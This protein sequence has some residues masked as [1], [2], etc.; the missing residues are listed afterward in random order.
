MEKQIKLKTKDGHTIYGILNTSSKKSSI[1]AVFV[2]GLTGHPNEHTFH[3]A[4]QQFPKKGVDVFRF[5]LYTG[6]KGGRKLSECTLTTHTEDLNKVLNHFR[7]KYKTIA[8]VGHSLGSPT[9]LK[10]DTSKVDSIVLWDPS[11]LAEDSGDRPN[12]K[13]KVNGKEKYIEEWGTEYLMNP[14]MVKEWEW[15]NG[16]NEL[17]IVANLNKPL[18]IIAAGNGI[19][20]KG[21]KEYFKVAQKPKNLTIVKGATHCFDE[22]GKED[23]LLSETLKWTKRY[24]KRN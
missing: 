12:K 15:F 8:V 14:A 20:V 11:Y 6:E 24:A 23:T 18:K 19:L 16:K 1:L 4:A 5:S 13:V 3:G 17:D 22:E 10:S 2:H 21:S 9:I 7:S